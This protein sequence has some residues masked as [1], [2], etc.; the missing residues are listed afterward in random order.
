MPYSARFL[1]GF[2]PPEF[3]HSKAE[4]AKIKP[5]ETELDRSTSQK[6]AY[7][8]SQP[9][10][11][12]FTE[13]TQ[14]ETEKNGFKTQIFPYSARDLAG[15]EPPETTKPEDESRMDTAKLDPLM[16]LSLIISVF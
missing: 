1:A 11:L 13:A 16:S 14:S 4:L 9:A 10:E 3:Q 15:F 5:T 8:K 12:K 2:E 7:S 6:T